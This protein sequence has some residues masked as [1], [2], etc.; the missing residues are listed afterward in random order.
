MSEGDTGG[1]LT[2]AI[3][4][5]ALLRKEDLVRGFVARQDLLERLLDDLRRV[6]LGSPPQHQLLIGQRG[7]GKTT[8]LRRLAFA[9]EDDP[10]LSTVWKPWFFRKSSTTSKTWAISG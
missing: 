1:L 5:P 8:L 2:T 6:Q 3:F 7:L 10:Q 4:N 9:I